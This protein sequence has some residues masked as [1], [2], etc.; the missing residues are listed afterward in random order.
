MSGPNR[1][2]MTDLLEQ[3]AT[4][5]YILLGDLRDLLDEPANDLACQWILAVLDALLETLPRDR[6][7]RAQGGYLSEVVEEFPNWTPLVDR[8]YQEK[9]ELYAK[10]SDL[11][12]RIAQ[13]A[14]FAS[15]LHEVR[16]DLRGWMTSFI[17]HHRHERR[18]VQSA[19]NIDVG[20]SGD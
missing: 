17:A 2:A 5:E 6:E 4:L 20:S 7:L 1:D 10:L 15:V 8:L 12:N 3:C 16:D 18:I 14:P 13:R 11:R 19:F 9:I